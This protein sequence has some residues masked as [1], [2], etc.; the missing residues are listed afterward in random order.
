MDSEKSFGIKPDDTMSNIKP[1]PLAS[2]FAVLLRIIVGGGTTSYARSHKDGKGTATTLL[3][4]GDSVTD[5]AW[6]R[7]GGNA[8][9]SDKRNHTD[10]NHIYGHSYMMLCASQLES[11]APDRQYQMLNRGISGDD[12]RRLQVR[13]PQDAIGNHPDVLS[14][15]EG[16]NDVLYYL[17][18]LQNKQT[19]LPFDMQAW[20]E[21]FRSVLAQSR[22][23][24]PD[25]IIMLGTPFVAKVGWVGD[26]SDFA[27]RDSLVSDMAERIRTMARDFDAI[28]VDYHQMFANLCADPDKAR[29]WIW[30]GIHPTPAGHRRMAD[31]WL[32]A[33]KRCE[34][35]LGRNQR[36]AD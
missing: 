14:L 24:N 29:H 1:L 9:P 33:Y 16:T 18:S 6:G 26:R 3:F 5:G 32:K 10:M 22:E 4:M 13:W 36:H 23:A 20:E 11:D 31:L 28:L 19:T 35:R 17:D 8:T 2:L 7:S 34:R 30:D 21:T 12:I 27:L 25:L 15:L